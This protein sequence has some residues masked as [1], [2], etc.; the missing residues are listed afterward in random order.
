MNKA[1]LGARI[2]KEAGLTKAG[3]NKALDAFVD[4]VTKSLRKGERVVLVGFGT[5][6][7]ARRKA[8]SVRNPRTAALIKIP[9]RKVPRFSAGK[10]LRK[11]IS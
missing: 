10:D 9:A 2:A 8:R 5:F 3:A 1:Q 6:G 7:T 4:I 11:N